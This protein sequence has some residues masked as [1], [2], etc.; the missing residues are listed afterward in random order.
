MRR[1]FEG[2]MVVHRHTGVIECFADTRRIAADQHDRA[3]PAGHWRGQR[4]KILALAVA[5]RDQHGLLREAIERGD[6]RADIRA[7]AVIDE[8]D[9][10]DLRNLFHAMRLALVFTQAVQQ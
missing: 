8:I 4:R 6:R 10:F 3:A 7:L 1:G 2:R 9:A 5:A